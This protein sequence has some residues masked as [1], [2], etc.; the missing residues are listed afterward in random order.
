MDMGKTILEY[1]GTI[2][3]ATAEI[4]S[5]FGSFF[6]DENNKNAETAFSSW[7]NLIFSIGMLF[8]DLKVGFLLVG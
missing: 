2:W 7:Q 4:F 8:E 3:G 5:L 6:V 1:W